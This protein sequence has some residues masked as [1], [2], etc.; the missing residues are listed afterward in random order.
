[1]KRG[2]RPITATYLQNAATLYLERYP[3]TAEGL[4]RILQRRVAKAR[5]A[6]APVMADVE[7]AIDAVVGKFVAIGAID[8]QAFAQTKAR[9]LH[10]RGASE[11]LTRRKLKLAG[12]DRDTLE[13]AL[14]GLDR[15]LDSERGEREWQAALALARRRRLGPFRPAADRAEHRMR[16]LAAMARAGFDYDLARKVIDSQEVA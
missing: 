4:R 8:D 7:Q 5:L 2:A 6:E 16:D 15:E 14:T 11:R 1:V 12:I 9:V 10:R 13:Q 3:T